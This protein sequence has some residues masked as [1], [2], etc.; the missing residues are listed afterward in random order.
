[1]INFTNYYWIRRD[2]TYILLT[3]LYLY[4]LEY[5]IFTNLPSQIL[6]DNINH[7]INYIMSSH[8]PILLYYKSIT[9]ATERPPQHILLLWSR[10]FVYSR[11]CVL[12]RSRPRQPIEQICYNNI[13]IVYD[14]I[15]WWAAC[16][17]T[18]QRYDKMS[19][20]SLRHLEFS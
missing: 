9:I 6:S 17:N 20:G 7:I 1:V 12:L 8:V 10:D 19:D 14:T 4:I 2:R 18:L 13:I 5:S 11:H 16:I 3:I 15:M